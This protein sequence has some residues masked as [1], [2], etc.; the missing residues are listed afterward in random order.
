MI[1]AKRIGD[2]GLARPGERFEFARRESANLTICRG[3]V[4][5]RAP[6]FSGRAGERATLDGMLNRVREGERAVL[7]MRGEAG[8][9]KTALIHQLRGAMLGEL[10]SFPERRQQALRLR[11]GAGAMSPG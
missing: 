2:W 11:S 5:G 6:A 4:V 7:V 8:I 9:G 1:D 3:V 10:D